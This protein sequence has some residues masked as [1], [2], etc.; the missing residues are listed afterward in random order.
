MKYVRK[1]SPDR[2]KIK[3]SIN[4][5]W[6]DIH[7]D[8]YK[9]YQIKKTKTKIQL[10]EISIDD[11]NSDCDKSFDVNTIGENKLLVIKTFN[12]DRYFVSTDRDAEKIYA[13]HED[14]GYENIS[15]DEVSAIYIVDTSDINYIIQMA[16]IIQLRD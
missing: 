9:Y 7:D 8:R 5:E 2:T 1:V 14:D 15:A 10:K 4:N 3:L 12:D 16:K 11:L 6:V 13:K